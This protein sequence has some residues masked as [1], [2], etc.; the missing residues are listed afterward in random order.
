MKGDDLNVLPVL[1]TDCRFW[2]GDRPCAFH[3]QEGVECE[4]RHYDQVKERVL[5][6]KLDA[7]GDVLRSTC[8]LPA[9]KARFP[10]AWVEWITRVESLP[11]LAENP[12]VDRTIAYGPDALLALSVSTYDWVVNLDAGRVSCELATM[13]RAVEK[14]GFVLDERGHIEPTNEAARGWLEMG[15]SD[16]LKRANTRTY[17]GVMAEILGVAG[18]P[19]GY[20]FQ[21]SSAEVSAGER[22]LADLGWV[23]GRPTLGLAT[24]AGGRWQLKQWREEAFGELIAEAFRRQPGLQILLLGG[25]EERDR[26]RRLM[27]A[28]PAVI[29]TGCDN[30]VRGFAALIRACDVVVTGDTLATHLS[31]AQGRRT[32][33]LFGPTSHH[34]IE[35]F[36]LGRKIYPDMDCLCC[37]LS[38][39]DK[40]PNC[41]QEI[42]T[43]V[44]LEAVEQELR[45]ASVSRPPESGA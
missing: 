7:M 9:I 26:N 5:I 32:V 41:M 33:V 23:P 37:Y 13:A 10:A 18:P 8:A 11:L 6:V 12:L 43:P 34:E 22:Q 3:K 20:V 19:A 31:L 38:A 2:R 25:P 30:P 27:L 35:M 29:D 1:S 28:H 45:V 16:R 44:V 40:S 36:G 24:G 42:R 17:Q 14:T 39:C 21:L 4:C 15:V